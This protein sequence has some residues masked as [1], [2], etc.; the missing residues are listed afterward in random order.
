MRHGSQS[1]GFAV[2]VW[3]NLCI[4]CPGLVELVRSNL[5]TSFPLFHGA[6]AICYAAWLSPPGIQQL[7]DTNILSD[8]KYRALDSGDQVAHFSRRNLI[9]TSFLEHVFGTN[10]LCDEQE[11][12]GGT[13]TSSGGHSHV[14]LE[15]VGCLVLLHLEPVTLQH[16]VIIPHFYQGLHLHTN[17]EVFYR[18]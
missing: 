6:G 10:S 17:K 4:C 13:S 5:G 18:M 15:R 8:A 11:P 14:K 1:H 7:F 12:A 2:R 3:S 9:Q 16:E